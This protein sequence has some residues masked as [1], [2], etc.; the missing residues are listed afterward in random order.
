MVLILVVSVPVVGSARG[1]LLAIAVIGMASCAVAGVGQA[2]VIGWTHPLTIF[3]AVVGVLALVVAAGGQLSL[4]E[5]LLGELMTLAAAFLWAVYMSF[6]A[7]FLRRHSPLMTSA[8]AMT[9][10]APRSP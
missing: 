8:W 10:G 3:G 6:G 9:G 7:P 1:A 4:G 2:P 5:K